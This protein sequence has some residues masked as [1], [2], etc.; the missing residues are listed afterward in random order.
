MGPVVRLWMWELKCMYGL[1]PRAECTLKETES[2]PQSAS[3]TAMIKHLIRRMI[4]CCV[5][6]VATGKAAVTDL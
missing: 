4:L 2:L 6:I 3:S 1:G 5:F